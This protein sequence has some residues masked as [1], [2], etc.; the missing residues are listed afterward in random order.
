MLKFGGL[1]RRRGWELNGTRL[2]EYY[3]EN[4]ARTAESFVMRVSIL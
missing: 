1:K 4:L 2:H 3:F